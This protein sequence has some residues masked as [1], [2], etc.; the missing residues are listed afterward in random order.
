MT[1]AQLNPMDELSFWDRLILRK[2]RQN[3]P[4]EKH[5][6]LPYQQ[7]KNI[8]FVV[9]V[10]RFQNLEAIKKA[11][12]QLEQG[13]R[14]VDLILLTRKKKTD[15]Q[16]VVVNFSRFLWMVKFDFSRA[17]EA[18]DKKYDLSIGY[19]T[20]RNVILEYFLTR[21]NALQTAL[22]YFADD[23][24][25]DILIKTSTEAV[26]NFISQIINFLTTIKTQ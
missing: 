16:D 20:Q 22:P 13:G 15:Y 5:L 17:Q 9:D 14:K 3:R 6:F 26:D 21:L 2:S 4:A 11:I 10:D 24:Q 23:T 8:A 25:A 7:V 12:K 1:K 18:K 19:D